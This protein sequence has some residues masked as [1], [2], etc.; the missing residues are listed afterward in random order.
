MQP[1]PGY[2]NYFATKEGKIYKKWLH[3]QANQYINV[4][5]GDITEVTPAKCGRDND[6]LKCRIGNRYVMLHQLI[7]LA[8]IPNPLN[9]P[10]VNHIDG[11]KLNNCVDNLEWATYSEQLKHAHD[12][13]IRNDKRAVLQYTL[14]GTFVAKFDCISDAS[15]AYAKGKNPRNS[16]TILKCCQGKYK[17]AYGY[18][19]H[20]ESEE[21]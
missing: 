18:I 5:A 13:G 7:A 14:D 2:D 3:S 21:D 20:Y 8:F 11:N 10:T 19:W 1:I 17:T 6:Y 4:I 9:K 15:E 16:S 12:N